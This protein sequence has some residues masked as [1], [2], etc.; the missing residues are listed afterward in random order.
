[1][2]V[3]RHEVPTGLESGEVELDELYSVR[4]D[5]GDD[6][7]LL[8]TDGPQPVDDL[9]SPSEQLAGR[10]LGAVW[11]NQGQMVG[12]SLSQGPKSEIGHSAPPFFA[13]SRHP[14]PVPRRQHPGTYL[15][16]VRRPGVAP[17]CGSS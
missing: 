15:G 5:G 2:V 16:G 6:I 3:Y 8:D 9:V 13:P 11:Q 10:E 12:I 1:M 14:L 17:S 4:Q 7:A